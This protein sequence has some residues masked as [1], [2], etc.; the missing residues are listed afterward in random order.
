[1][2]IGVEESSRR[3]HR[4]FYSQPDGVPFVA[5]QDEK[6]GTV[7]TILPIDYHNRCA[8]HVSY[9][10]QK[11]A[12]AIITG[13]PRRKKKEKDIIKDIT[14]SGQ[15]PSHYRIKGILYRENKSILIQKNLGSMPRQKHSDDAEDLLE[16]G[17]FAEE[18]KARV[19]DKFDDDIDLDRLEIEIRAGKDGPGYYLFYED[20][21][22]FGSYDDVMRNLARR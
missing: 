15:Q 8:W 21:I 2:N 5:I 18:L 20:A 14:A 7:V 1:M 11:S 19:E 13:V 9:D 12:E 6:C 17:G 22:S 4:L 16:S 3:V 10:A